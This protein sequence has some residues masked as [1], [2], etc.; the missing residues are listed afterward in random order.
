MVYRNNL[1]EA[2]DMPP[3]LPPDQSGRLSE[4]DL[5]ILGSREV[6]LCIPIVSL[7]DLD[8]VADQLAGLVSTMRALRVTGRSG[9]ERHA[10]FILKKEVERANEVIRDHYREVFA[11]LRLL[12]PSK[13]G[14]PR[15]G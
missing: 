7:Q 1:A 8:V 2:T 3:T 15:N 9:P 10:L 13:G 14:R 4:M 12:P 6:R 5:N 11:R